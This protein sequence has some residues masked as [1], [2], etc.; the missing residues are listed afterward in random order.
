MPVL[1]FPQTHTANRASRTNSVLMLAR[2]PKNDDHDSGSPIASNQEPTETIIH[3][4]E[5][6]DEDVTEGEPD[7]V[8]GDSGEYTAKAVLET[9]PPSAEKPLYDT[10]RRELPLFLVEPSNQAVSIRSQPQPE[11][12]NNNLTLS[13]SLQ[14]SRPETKTAD[15]NKNDNEEDNKDDDD[16]E[17]WKHMGS[18]SKSNLKAIDGAYRLENPN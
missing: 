5:K 9:G 11:P 3:I 2:P 13:Q 16:S 10:P 6:P 1:T 15:V 14:I 7:S 4:E 17:S 12:N 18:V 8:F